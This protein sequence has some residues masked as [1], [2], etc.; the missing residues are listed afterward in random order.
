MKF[1]PCLAE[2]EF[3]SGKD[4]FF[5]SQPIILQNGMAG[6]RDDYGF[7]GMN[8]MFGGMNVIS[9]GMSMIKRRDDYDY[10]RD[11]LIPHFEF[12]TPDVVDVQMHLL[13][14]PGP[15]L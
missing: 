4:N 3:T 6:R 1:K 13:N 12:G 2:P 10:R 5:C 14:I 9:G 15:S 7:G 8:V 11:E